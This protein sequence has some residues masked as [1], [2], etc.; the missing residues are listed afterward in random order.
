[1][2]LRGI[3]VGGAIVSTIKNVAR[4]YHQQKEKGWNK[5]D[6]IIVQEALQISPPAGIK[7]RKLSSFEKTMLFNRKVIP[8]M[9]PYDIDNPMWE[10][11]ANLIEG[12]TNAPTARFYRKQENVRAAL[13][14]R[15]QYWQRVF[16][17][18]GWD[19]WSLGVKDYEIEAVKEHIKKTNKQINKD[20]KSKKR[21][22]PTR[23]F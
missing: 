16:L 12:T 2:V 22:F 14:S 23:T 21:K 4:K 17:F 13:D 8:N 1:M 6:N 18:G 15:N 10:A 11:Y 19:K 5:E 7:A 20:T 3:G 9:S